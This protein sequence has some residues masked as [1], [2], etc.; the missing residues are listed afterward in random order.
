MPKTLILDSS[1]IACFMECPQKWKLQYDERL[2]TSLG[3]PREDFTMGTY[4]HKLLEIYYQSLADGLSQSKA[5]SASFTFDP[6]Y[7]DCKCGH[8][9]E[10]H[11]SECQEICG[12]LSFDPILF[13]L[14]QDKRELIRKRFDDYWMMHSRNDISPQ[15]VEKG[16]SYPL[17]DDEEWLFILE[18]RIDII[19]LFA[20]QQVFMD[21]KWQGRAHELYT[22][23]IQ[24]RNYSLATGLPIGVINYIRLQKEVSKDTFVRRVIQFSS[25]ERSFWKQRLISIYKRIAK[26]IEDGCEMNE[27]SCAGRFGIPCEFTRVCEEPNDLIRIAI[28]E[29]TFHKKEEWKP[30]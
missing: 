12:C 11:V 18:G 20:G 14:S 8:H 29:N 28:K 27:S 21:H 7:Q 4:G 22:K 19:G 6:D 13:P 3:L 17:L 23:A 2:T 10:S 24:F 30:W 5:V 25:L 1:Q 16:F 15:I 26:S 9:R